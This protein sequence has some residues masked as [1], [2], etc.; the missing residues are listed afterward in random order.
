MTYANGREA[1]WMALGFSSRKQN[2]VLYPRV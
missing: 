2:L 1:D